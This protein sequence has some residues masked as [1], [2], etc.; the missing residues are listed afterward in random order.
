MGVTAWFSDSASTSTAVVDIFCRCEPGGN[1]CKCLRFLL[2]WP[3]SR[4][5][6]QTRY[7]HGPC[8]PPTM[9]GVFHP[10]SPSSLNRTSCSSARAEEALCCG[11]GYTTWHIKPYVSCLPLQPD[12]SLSL[13]APCCSPGL[14]IWY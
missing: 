11:V 8:L 12:V 7:E 9:A 3:P 14:V 2:Y 5:A 1:S 4:S 10:F 6:M 13:V